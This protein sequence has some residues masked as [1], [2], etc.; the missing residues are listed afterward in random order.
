MSFDIVTGAWSRAALQPRLSQEISRARRGGGSCSVFL[1][2]VD[3]FK[4]VNDVYGHLRGDAVLRQI[5]DR[6]TAAMR[7]DDTVFRYGGDEFVVLLPDTDRQ[8][9]LHLALRL[10]ELVRSSPFD[11]EPPLHISISLGVATY[12]NDADDAISLLRAADRRNYLAKHRGRGGAV[13]DDSDTAAAGG[14]SRLWERDEA[15]SATHDFLTKLTAHGR[16]SLQVNGPPGAGHTRFLQEVQRLAVLR[17]F[18]VVAPGAEM[19]PPGDE[20]TTVPPAPVLL[21]ADTDTAGDLAATVARWTE[22][23]T[24]PHALGVAYA[25]VNTP[26]PP[27]PAVPLLASVDLTPWSP[28]TQRIWLR[29]VLQGEP[30]DVLADWIARESGGLPAAA[31]RELGR[32][33]QRDGVES[34]GAGGWT[35]SSALLSRPRRQVRLPAPVTGLVGREHERARVAELL[36]AGRLVT[37]VGPGG[38]GKTRLS[39]SAATDVADDFH[40][41][42]VFVALADTSTPD[43]VVR[44]LAGALHV[45]E[46]PG[47]PLI[48][49]VT[50]HLADASQ[51]LVLDNLEQVVSAAPL[52]GQLINDAPGLVVL[53]T[54]REPLSVYGE[55][56]YR[57]PPLPLPDLQALP[58]GADGVA[59]ALS[60]S[61]AVALF[62]QRARAAG[63]AFVLRPD[64]LPAVAELCRLLDGLPLAIELAAA[65]T[66]AMDAVDLLEHLRRHLDALGGGPADRPER[67]QTLRGAIDWSYE[68]LDPDARRLF[69][70]TAVFTGG[71]TVPAALAV[72]D[73]DT[74][75][76]DVDARLKELAGRLDSLAA[77]SLL[78]CDHDPD[79][80][81]RYRMLE[82]IRAYAAA[83]LAER[84]A[85]PVRDRHLGYF[86]GL[87]DAA[88]DG[89]AG[90]QQTE[91]VE[92]IDR[93]HANLRA[94]AGW[95]LER[96]HPSSAG[97]IC[98]GLWRYWR[99]GNHI[100]D[101]RQWFDRVLSAA[102]GPTGRERAAL[103]YPAAVLAATQDDDD[104]ATRYGRECLTLADTA[105]DRQTTAQARNI[106]GV[107]AL[108]VGRFDE[109]TEHFGFGLEVWRELGQPQ[110][111]AMALGNLAKLCL[112]QGRVDEAADHIQQCLALERAAG[113]SSGVLLGLECLGEVLLARGDHAGAREAAG[114][115]LA[116]SRELGDVFGEAMALHQS[117]LAARTAGDTDEARELFLT[118]MDLRHQVGDREDLAV[119][120]DCV[121]ELLVGTD[122]QRAVRLL[123]GADR[124]RQSRNLITPADDGRR[125]AAITAARSALGGSAFAAA[126]RAGRGT[127]LEAL[128]PQAH[129]H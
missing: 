1:F 95:S 118:A 99:N 52:I 35:V 121:A 42:V 13:A 88:A 29:S 22:A 55:H 76:D 77:K 40:D 116:L 33:R 18:T 61:P 74:A 85:T 78:V 3:F 23:A 2:D 119:S 100:G 67:Q 122:P 50:E 120:L 6:V 5:A 127:A 105:G 36:H 56:V 16:G 92:R 123:A 69:E 60:R 89:M 47:Q 111:M 4:T 25:C 43:E 93:D 125:D 20:S 39:L 28:A 104:A 7:L 64:T 48:E 26:V 63:G 12:P 80:E 102:P 114:E 9:A 106:L 97:R 62:D 58:Q 11:G 57:V 79:G 46:V 124:L 10:T 109:A 83:R 91:W 51:L 14:S 128:L 17:G 37:L 115:A 49:G 72:A 82:T 87:A 113:N 94:A 27:P 15:L 98:L 71:C 103:L 24:P 41:G 129:G 107:A 101:G 84:D 66:D 19:S 117:G 30:S 31:V 126:W 32:L 34:D 21:L 110:G 90:P 81:P 45:D 112:R 73:P 65:R 54:S 38:I 96:G 53:A 68:L 75:V 86:L 8:A 70:A 59:V 108:R 44:A